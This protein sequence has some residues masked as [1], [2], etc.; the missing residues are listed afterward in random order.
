MELCFKEK[1]VLLVT[2]GTTP[3]PGDNAP[4]AEKLAWEN[5]DTVAQRMIS[6]VV[7]LPVLENLV[8]CTSAASMW[9]TLCSLYQQKSKENVYM[10][11][12][13]F[14]EYK[15]SPGDT[16]NSH[17]NKVLSLASLLKE[18]GQPQTEDAL[19]TKI[20]CTLPP[21]YNHIVSGWNNV[22]ADEQNIATLKARCLQLENLMKLQGDENTS[23]SAFLARSGKAS[24]KGKKHTSEQSKEYMK[25]LKSKTRCYNCG[26][27]DH[28][29]AECPHPRRDKLKFPNQKQHKS[30]HPE[31]DPHSKHS[32]VWV[33]TTE[34]SNSGSNNSSSESDAQVSDADSCAFTMASKQSH[35]LSVN[36]DKT[37]WFADSG[38]T[39]HM[40]E[41]RNWFSTFKPIP[42]GS[43]SVTVADDR[44]I[45]VQGIGDIQI[46][47][48]VDGIEKKGV[49]RKV[50]FIPE[51]RRNLFSIGIASKAG[52]SFQT[53]G[54]TCA[55][56]QHLGRGPKVMEGVQI[57]TLYKLSIK[58]VIPTQH[59]KIVSP[60]PSTA[61]ATTTMPN[62]DLTLWHNRMAHINVQTIKSMSTHRSLDDFSVTPSGHLHS[63][64]R[65]CAL[66]KQHKATYPSSSQKERSKIPGELLHAGLCGKMS[67]PSL[68]GAHY[69][70]LIKDDCTSYRFVAFLRAKS[71]AIRFFIKVIRSIANTTG[72]RVKTLRTDRGKEF[73][74]TE[75][76]LLLEREGITRETSTSY[77]PQ[78][79]GYVERDNRTICEAAHSM[80]HLH[81]VPLKLWAE[82]IH[83]AVH[84]LNRTINTQVGFTTPYELWFHR[85]PSVSHY[86]T[87]GTLA[88]I[89]IDKS[90]RT[91]FQPKG[92]SVI[93]VGYSDTSKA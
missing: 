80:L 68:G 42:K 40:T 48:T 30:E 57:G 11:Q 28:W 5:A 75:F 26:E 72:N 60:T 52:Y 86:R 64:C 90:L 62:T 33:A 3:K 36:L 83:T 10:V 38:A 23:D 19:I 16:I 1:H 24:A 70:I 58:P 25:E 34:Q 81:D 77:T 7:S 21:S 32:E 74:N 27:H 69:Y 87:F 29:T 91:K 12:N 53:L 17:I 89:F 4:E 22:P 35:V 82:L 88:Y 37:A 43:W 45:W 31:K 61:F 18:L 56:Y 41:H 2:N 14:Y 63:I 20:M 51:L 84:I 15:M 49:L 50:L 6:S 46:T 66:G 54:D 55:I 39:E 8:S 44:H 71:D 9:S 65:G 78:Q 73:C 79:N 47:R 76:D 93:F 85:K 67:Q 92:T 59:D 13:S